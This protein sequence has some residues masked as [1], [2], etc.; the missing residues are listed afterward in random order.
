MTS[1]LRAHDAF[2]L[3][4]QTGAPARAGAVAKACARRAPKK[5]LTGEED[6]VVA[7]LTSIADA[8][9]HRSG[10]ARGRSP[11]SRGN[12]EKV[13]DENALKTAA[14]KLKA[15]SL[16]AGD[17]ALRA[18]SI[19]RDSEGR[20][21]RP[22]EDARARPPIP[23]LKK[24]LRSSDAAVRGTSATGLGALGVHDALDDLFAAFDHGVAE[25]AAAIGQL[26][27]P[28]E[29]EKFADR[30]GHVTFD[31]MVTGF[32]SDPVS[33]TE[34]N[35]RRR[36]DSSSRHAQGARHAGGRKISRGR[37]RAL[38]ERLEQEGEASHRLRFPRD[39][40]RVQ[41]MMRASLSKGLVA[42]ALA[43]AA[44]GGAVRTAPFSADWQSDNG[45]SIAAIQ[46]RLNDGEVAGESRASSSA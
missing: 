6:D 8:G 15:S 35:P 40:W 41:E 42:C 25:A 44:C 27:H 24:G 37:R 30:T 29:C 21:T 28:D 18:A 17:G 1:T 32:R 7:A 45:T 11:R 13:L 33:T 46:A 23:A 22:L 12:D 4:G 2:G 5:Q 39:R 10:A 31:V 34:R 26:C 19:R 3:Q 9:E 43:T 20:R 36:E 14:G 38:A 16:S